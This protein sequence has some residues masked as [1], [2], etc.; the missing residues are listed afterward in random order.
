MMVIRM[1][2]ARRNLRTTRGAS[3]IL[4]ALCAIGL[5][6]LVYLAFQMAL[7][8]GGSREV[9]NAVDAAI[10]NVSKKV[11]TLK[12]KPDI[13]VDCADSSGMVGMSNISRVWGKAYL[14]NA[15]VDGMKN[16]G[17]VTGL[18]SGAA[19]K[20]YSS[21]QQVNDNLRSQLTSKGILDQFFDQLSA[22]KPARLLGSAATATPSESIS[23]GGWATAMVDRGAESNLTIS[24]GQLPPS[25]QPKQVNRGN[26]S[27]LQGYTPMT[28]NG[29]EFLFPSFRLGEM[30][31]L[32]SDIQFTQGSLGGLPTNPIPNAFRE[33]ASAAGAGTS[34]SASACAEANPQRQYQLAIPQGYVTI[35][36]ANQAQWIVEGKKVNQTTYGF[37]PEQ[38][39]GAK[40]IKLSVGGVLDGFGNL[41]NE[42]KLG[43]LWQLFNACPGDHSVPLGKL[44]QR[45][46]EI[47]PT[48]TPQRLQQLMT[49]AN[50]MPGASKYYIFP[51]YSSPDFT[52]PTIKIA[53]VPGPQMPAWLLTAVAAEGS[54]AVIATE[55]PPSI[56]EPNTCYDNIVGGKSPT[57]K[58]WT[59]FY[60]SISWQPGT[61]MSQCL[62]DLKMSRT[63]RCIFTGVP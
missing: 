25:V 29:K 38:Q 63:T 36:F 2:K 22:S 16:D 12:V 59:E 48:F 37:Q 6:F 43:S 56:D 18:A 14:I 40:K 17:L 31:H 44:V 62:G 54:T 20:A 52:N 8:M 53:S 35:T 30:P 7:I 50:L 27:Y 45:V 34:L 42:Y 60:G 10:L 46:K 23:A 47:D 1:K 11:V 3:I 33:L 41:G 55:V 49:S 51:Q 26:R 39:Q 58:H 24:N 61:G 15:N 19:D 28:A 4:V 5:I 9:R 21:A 57:G 32:I 13:F